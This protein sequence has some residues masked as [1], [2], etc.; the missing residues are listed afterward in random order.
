MA[1][2]YFRFGL[3]YLEGISGID[4][5]GLEYRS[6]YTAFETTFVRDSVF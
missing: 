3:T 5:S 4:M 6:P 1:P 2:G